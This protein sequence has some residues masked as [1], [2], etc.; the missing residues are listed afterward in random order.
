MFYSREVTDLYP[1][2]RVGPEF[3][4]IAP[5]RFVNSVDLA[6]TPEELFDVLADAASWPRWAKVITGVEWTTPPPR[7]VGTKRTVTMRGG[8]LGVEEFLLWDA[9]TRI[10]FRFNEASEKRIRAFAERYD[11][12]PTP[13]GCRL[14][15]TLALEVAG[16][17]R[18]TLGPARPLLDLG[19]RWFLRNLRRYTDQRYGAAAG[20]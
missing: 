11:V 8:L 4:D 6:I 5:V 16:A 1:C 7:G 18:L 20:T 10:A 3:V 17:A 19:F 12:E 13:E 2:E 14:T 9:P 15:W